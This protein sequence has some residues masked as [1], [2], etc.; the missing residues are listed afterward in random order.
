MRARV[1]SGTEDCQ[2]YMH[3]TSWSTAS[4]A[5][6]RQVRNSIA[7]P[8]DGGSVVHTVPWH[9]GRSWVRG[10]DGRPTDWDCR[11][12]DAG[13]ALCKRLAVCTMRACRGGLHERPVV[14]CMPM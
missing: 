4:L 2:V 11:R 5:V 6:R 14:C 7:V 13:E 12:S 1:G 3:F 8:L 9:V 10:K